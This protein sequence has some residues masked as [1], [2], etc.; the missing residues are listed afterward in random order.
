MIT[1]FNLILI[2]FLIFII[3]QIYFY[4]QKYK[5]NQQIINNLEK[6]ESKIINIKE[7]KDYFYLDDKSL[8][9]LLDDYN[10]IKYHK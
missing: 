2:L 1:T 4:S 9:N 5:E 6:F 10:K 7:K 8:E 3:V